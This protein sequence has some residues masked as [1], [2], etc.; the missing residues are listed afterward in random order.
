MH[1]CLQITN[2]GIQCKFLN[3]LFGYIDEGHLLEDLSKYHEGNLLTAYILY[4]DHAVKVTHFTTFELDLAQLPEYK[5][6]TTVTAEVSCLIL[7]FFIF[8]NRLYFKEGREL[9]KI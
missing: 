3:D 2:T 5:I 6:G 4:I 1:N 8:I 7:K 9:S